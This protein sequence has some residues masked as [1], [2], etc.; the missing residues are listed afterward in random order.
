MN[1]RKM[2]VMVLVV[3]LAGCSESPPPSQI[4][5]EVKSSDDLEI[6][7]EEAK[8]GTPPPS[9][10]RPE[11]KSADDM[12]VD[13]EAAKEGAQDVEKWRQEKRELSAK[14]REQMLQIHEANRWILHS[15]C[16]GRVVW[17]FHW[18]WPRQVIG[19]LRG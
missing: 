4:R 11:E 2:C 17:I 9:H 6:D 19:R 3:G 1:M 7:R 8:K 13:W 15:A 10:I 14:K 5:P 12:K 16:C 18:R